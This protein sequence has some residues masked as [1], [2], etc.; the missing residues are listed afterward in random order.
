M[1]PV[2]HLVEI[3]EA[4]QA[5]AVSPEAAAWFSR[6]V[7]RYLL[8]A[9]TLD[10]CLQLNGGPGIRKALTDYLK[11]KRDY[12][13]RKAWEALDTPGPWTRSV[14]LSK[15]VKRFK[16]TAWPRLCAVDELPE[17]ASDLRR[18]LWAA[19]K[20]GLPVPVSPSQLD[21]ICSAPVNGWYSSG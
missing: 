1:N 18:H 17:S 15:A 14:E 9:G 2:D 12:H 7:E 20:T 11:N 21:D 10:E 3:H 19:F 13:L 6:G 8:R 16:G 4:L 5:G